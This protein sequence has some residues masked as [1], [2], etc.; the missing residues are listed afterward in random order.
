MRERK[1]AI[2]TM[3]LLGIFAALY[4]V[5]V[6]T[7]MVIRVFKLFV[8][9]SW[10]L[11][12]LFFIVSQIL[13][14]KDRIALAN[15]DP[16]YATC[17]CS[18]IT[19]LNGTYKNMLSL[20][21]LLNVMSFI[22][23]ALTVFGYYYQYKNTKLYEYY[24]IIVTTLVVTLEI[25]CVF[26]F[27]RE[28][29]ASSYDEAVIKVVQT[30]ENWEQEGR[31]IREANSTKDKAEDLE[32]VSEDIQINDVSVAVSS[33]AEEDDSEGATCELDFGDIELS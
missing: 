24:P 14:A 22:S 29:K 30:S 19:T 31:D 1:S 33:T 16:Q 8:P 25:L 6:P 15:A 13:F 32:E 4:E 20:I 3:L 17:S 12:V 18:P 5:L 28:G 10:V 7:V 26:V 2:V 9:I 11:V 23:I 21:N 27:T